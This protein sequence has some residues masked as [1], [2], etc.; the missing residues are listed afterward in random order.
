MTLNYE[1]IIL[2]F[3][4][5][6]L[7]IVLGWKLKKLYKNILLNYYNI[8]GKSAEKKAYNIL[9][10]NNYTVIKE[11]EVIYGILYENEVRIMYKIVPDFLVEKNG[12]KMF[13]E[14]KTGK[15]ASIS[16]RFTRRQLL[17]Y[18]YLLD[19]SLSLLIDTEKGII[20]KIKFE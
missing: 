17:E 9:I 14:V 4:L 6:C 10:K 7:L 19:T 1:Y 5:S 13:A 11:Q 3:F 15:S 8:R 18:S 2:I 20:K 16:N 12:I